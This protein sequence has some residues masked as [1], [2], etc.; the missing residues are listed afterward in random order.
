MSVL[1]FCDMNDDPLECGVAD[2]KAD[3]PSDAAKTLL[4]LGLDCTAGSR[5]RQAEKRPTVS[6]CLETLS[7]FLELKVDEE[8]TMFIKGQTLTGGISELEVRPSETISEVK[9]QIRMRNHNIQGDVVLLFI[10]DRNPHDQKKPLPD[11]E[12]VGSCGIEQGDN[13]K[14]IIL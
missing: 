3:W 6:D 14:I 11:G 4:D 2:P 5:A 13:L 1:D 9:A 10:N 12:T 8:G 7:H